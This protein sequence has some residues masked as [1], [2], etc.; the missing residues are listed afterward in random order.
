LGADQ[1]KAE[2]RR[3]DVDITSELFRLQRQKGRRAMAWDAA[4]ELVRASVGAP[5]SD[6]YRLATQKVI[7]EILRHLGQVAPETEEE[8]PRFTAAL[9]DPTAVLITTTLVATCL[10]EQVAGQTGILI[11]EAISRAVTRVAT[12]GKRSVS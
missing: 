1:E 10:A 2:V 8:I 5:D 6:R 9:A 4:F 7:E 3:R 12:E 11:D